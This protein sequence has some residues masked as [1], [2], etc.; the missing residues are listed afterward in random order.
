VEQFRDVI[1]RV[2]QLRT[3]LELPRSRFAKAIG[4]T[5]QT[6]NNFVGAQASKPS[7]KLIFGIVNAFNVNPMWLLMGKG[8]VFR[9]GRP[10]PNPGA[11][12]EVA[13]D[14]AIEELWTT[15]RYLERRIVALET[16]GNRERK[17]R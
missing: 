2:E 12:H 10:Q 7:V 8:E 15:I 3:Q 11:I 6:Y 4:M 16:N 1:D 14:K 13:R 17:R 5:P 9:P